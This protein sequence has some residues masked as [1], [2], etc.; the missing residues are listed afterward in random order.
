MKNET[1]L[2]K[3]SPRKK[4][5]FF[6]IMVAGTLLGALVIAEIVLRV[7]PIPGVGF[8]IAHLDTL[9]GASYFPNRT[10]VYR[11]DRGDYAKTRTNRWGFF[12]KD[13]TREKKAG[14][15]RIG[16]FG[17]SYTQAIQVPLTE[18]FHYRIGDSLKEQ[19]IETLAFGFSGFSTYQS[20]L[21][22]N[23]WA[24]YFDLDMIVYV[25]CENDPGD[26][27][28]I[29]KKSA[30]MPYP[31]L[32][33]GQL[34]ADT[35]FKELVKQQSTPYNR[36]LD[37]LKENS[38]VLNTLAERIQ[39]LKRYGI[40]MRVTEKDRTGTGGKDGIGLTICP[41]QL[42]QMDDPSLWPDSLKVLATGLQKAVLL[43]WKNEAIK[44][45]KRFAVLYTPKT[46]MIPATEQ[47]S[48]KSMLE[49]FC[50]ENN[51]PFIDPTDELTALQKKGN[52][53]IYDHYTKYGHEGVAGAFIKYYLASQKP[54]A[55]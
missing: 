40:K 54:T 50:R 38:L 46:V 7:V 48:W 17:D 53:V 52:D 19:Q 30:A 44:N 18:T 31:L 45:K 42:N 26:Q 8:S 3:M 16:F 33:N 21:N 9:T 28:R 25:F 10:V 11:N 12:D 43:A 4:I 34:V 14:I 29:I 20:Y 6:L 37:Y 39:L 35:S 32:R 13:H 36:F 41:P 27:L 47:N 49:K 51:I 15:T 24:D 5:L 22:S 2:Q 55:Q 1:D 23:R